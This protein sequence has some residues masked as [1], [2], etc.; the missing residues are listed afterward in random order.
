MAA[1][2][3]SISILMPRA[4]HFLEDG[5]FLKTENIEAPTLTADDYFRYCRIAYIAGKRIGETVNEALSGREMY[6]LYADGRHEGL[7]EIAPDSTQE[8]A[9]WI[10]GKHPKRTLGGHPWEIMRGGN[11]THIDLIVSRP[12]LYRKE[13]FKVELR[14]ESTG[15]MAEMLRMFLAIH[16]AGQPL[17]SPGS[18]CRSCNRYPAWKVPRQMIRPGSFAGQ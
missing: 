2:C 11:T 9:D 10:D 1:S 16:R 5:F 17:S 12:S 14:A 3:I 4:L 8:L 15:R 18:R 13:G 7:L 6:G